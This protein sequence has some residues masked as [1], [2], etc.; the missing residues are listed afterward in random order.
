M[1]S[2]LNSALSVYEV[3]RSRCT[4]TQHL[5]LVETDSTYASTDYDNDNVDDDNHYYGDDDDD[6]NDNHKLFCR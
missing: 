5:R 1:N 3:I 4:H 2:A 6:D